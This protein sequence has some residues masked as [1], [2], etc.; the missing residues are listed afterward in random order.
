MI[1]DE[2]NTDMD[3]NSDSPLLRAERELRHLQKTMDRGDFVPRLQPK[4]YSRT[5]C[6][7]CVNG[8]AMVID[9]LTSSARNSS[10]TVAG[11]G[12]KKVEKTVNFVATLKRAS[13]M[14]TRQAVAGSSDNFQSA[15]LSS[16]TRF[17]VGVQQ[18]GS[19]SAAS[20]GDVRKEREISSELAGKR[21]RN[22]SPTSKSSASSEFMLVLNA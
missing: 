14:Q 12:P 13:G 1:S 22:P 3:N 7:G 11:R 2:E 6:Y 21:T 5:D 20:P 4:K 19:R 18:M 9:T 16:P 10:S 17:D 15:S 8:D